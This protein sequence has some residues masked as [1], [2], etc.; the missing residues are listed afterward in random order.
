MLVF[1]YGTLKTGQPNHG[2]MQ[3]Q[4]PGQCIFIGRGV[5]LDKYPLVVATDYHAPFLLY[6]PGT[7]HVSLAIIK[8]RATIILFR[9][10]LVRTFYLNAV[11]PVLNGHSKRRPKIG[12]QDRCSL[13]AGQKHCR[14]LQESILQYVRLS[15]S[16]H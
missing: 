10:H 4:K 2:R 13:N 8:P 12:F 14:M 6:K 7:G 11:K 1:T 16:N 5:T 3:N 15:L 9:L